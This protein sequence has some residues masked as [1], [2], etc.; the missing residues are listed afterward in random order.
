VLAPGRDVRRDAPRRPVRRATEIASCSKRNA[1]A[2]AAAA[3]ERRTRTTRTNKYILVSKRC[4]L[5]RRCRRAAA[6][7]AAA[8]FGSAR[9]LCVHA[10]VFVCLD[11]RQLL[12]ANIRLIRRPLIRRRSVCMWSTGSPSSTHGQGPTTRA[13]HSAR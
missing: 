11:G 12:P 2:A 4:C 6:A 10:V 8:A 9:K 3:A 13:V 7:A 1:A 5:R